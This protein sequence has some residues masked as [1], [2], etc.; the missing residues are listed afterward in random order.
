MPVVK[1]G[2]RLFKRIAVALAMGI[3]ALA[4]PIRMANA[5][6]P[7]LDN[8]AHCLSQKKATMYGAFYCQHCA[9]QKELFGKSFAY[10]TYQECAIMGAPGQQTD[11]CKYMQIRKYP[12]WIFADNERREGEQSLESLAEKTGCKLP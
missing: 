11:Q 3:L 12:T 6:A 2:T 4:M 7:N 5:A 8:F 10:V 1:S 9:K